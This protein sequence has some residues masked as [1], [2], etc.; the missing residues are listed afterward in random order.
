MISDLTLRTVLDNARRHRLLAAAVQVHGNQALEPA[1]LDVSVRVAFELEK[2]I[3]A[4]MRDRDT[5]KP[6]TSAT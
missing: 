1:A 5:L 4:G 2:R 3:E 6:Q